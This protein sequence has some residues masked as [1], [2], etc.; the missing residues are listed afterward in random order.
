MEQINFDA[1]ALNKSEGFSWEVAH[2]LQI[3]LI[4][5]SNIDPL[6]WIEKNSA[7]Y[8]EFINSH[9][10]LASLYSSEKGRMKLKEIISKELESRKK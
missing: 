6:E 7:R 3:E 5:E 2:N 1:D 9:S 10:E 4:K 8:R